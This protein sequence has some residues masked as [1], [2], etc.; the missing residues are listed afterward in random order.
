LHRYEA[1]CGWA[2]RI[3]WKN[4]DVLITV[5]NRCVNEVLERQVPGLGAITRVLTVP[6]GV[7]A[8]KIKFLRRKRGKSLAFVGNLR[9]VKNPMLLLQCMH[10]LCSEDPG[11]RL[12]I[13]GKTQDLEVEQYVRHM[14]EALGLQDH[15]L[16]DGWQGDVQQWLADKHYVVLT[17]VIESQGMGVLEAMAAGLKPVV[18]NFPGA[19]GI[20]P[21]ESL[22][23]TPEEFC[24]I[25]RSED[26][27]PA[28]YR[29]FVEERYSLAAQLEQINRLLGG[30]EA[31]PVRRPGTEICAV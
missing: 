25:V 31:N 17:S 22:F 15:V 3:E 6:N 12:Y 18:H 5:G 1:Y 26:Y 2:Q 4:I 10:R 27:A 21:Q 13:A 23:N 14:I 30:L 19:D 20:Y 9:F 28:R 8:G 11:Y 16:L 24:R 29:A 7:D